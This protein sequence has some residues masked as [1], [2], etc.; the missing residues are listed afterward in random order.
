M[1]LKLT[2]LARLSIYG[3]LS[4]LINIKLNINLNMNFN[5][6]LT[7]HKKSIMI[8]GT[9]SGVGKS[10]TVTAICR[11]LKKMGEKPVPFKG[12]NMSNNAWVD[13]DGGE[14]AYSQ[15]LQAF[16]SGVPPSSCM[17][18]VLLKP[19]GNSTSEV[20]HLGKSK[21]ITTAK[22]YYK[23]WFNSGWE[24][25]KKG[26]KIIFDEDPNNRLIIEGAGSPVEMNLIHRDLTNLR[27]ARYLD[28][29]CILVADI[30]KGG[31]FAQIIG[32]LELMQ[33]EEKKL[34]KGIIINRFRGDLS[35]FSEG[36]KWIE[37]KTKIP[38]LGILPVLDLSLI[39]I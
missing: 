17:N 10:L 39:H 6:K 9:S 25:I 11:I 16:A 35:L 3:F 12:Q 37:N 30:E 15:A 23:N 4:R 5:E 18:P 1:K 22:N 20:I 21:G 13:L 2:L 26:I 38:I 28:A 19:N 31:V 34:I 33:P 14:M 8:L 27:I 32:T 29:D 36:K 7:T 24:A